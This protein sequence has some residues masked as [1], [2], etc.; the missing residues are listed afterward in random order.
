MQPRPEQQLVAD[1]TIAAHR[2][3]L[4]TITEAGTG[5]GKTV[6]S[7]LQAKAVSDEHPDKTVLILVPTRDKVFATHLTAKA[8]GIETHPYPSQKRI[9]CIKQYPG[10]TDL[11]HA[12]LDSPLCVAPDG[13]GG[14]G[15]MPTGGSSKR[16]ADGCCVKRP[17]SSGIVIMTAAMHNVL[18][19]HT[20]LL[21][22]SVVALIVDEAHSWFRNSFDSEGPE[23]TVPKQFV[24]AATANDV[25]LGTAPDTQLLNAYIRGLKRKKT[26]S[27]EQSDEGVT[28][29]QMREFYTH[30]SAHWFASYVA[31]L[32]GWRVHTVRYA[33]PL[34]FT[35]DTDVT[36]HLLTATAHDTMRSHFDAINTSSL[37]G[38]PKANRTTVRVNPGTAPSTFHL[39]VRTLETILNGPG[40]GVLVLFT[41]RRAMEQFAEA[42]GKVYPNLIVQGETLTMAEL[43]QIMKEDNGQSRYV[44]CGLDGLSEGL[45]LPG[46]ALTD[47]VLASTARITPTSAIGMWLHHLYRSGGTER[48]IGR[49][50]SEDSLWW[51]SKVADDLYDTRLRQ[52]AG[53]LLR[54]PEDTGRVWVL[55]DP[56][57]QRIDQ[58]LLRWLHIHESAVQ[59]HPT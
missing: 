58:A 48:M 40:G 55:M 53:R 54:G 17:Y 11:E 6:V 29:E 46:Q 30:P 7:V 19:T 25:Y 47:V 31:A 10:A 27:T 51:R 4:N 20:P 45:D 13:E 24:Q 57:K 5:S 26:M 49:P 8:L 42:F 41:A 52:S 33:S 50:L 23:V 22:D 35:R 9:L 44:A 38:I 21:G 3:G 59:W 12:C 16:C 14:H 37:T 28:E 1:E 18:F 56:T 34:R 2:Q 32:E 43:T 15:I 36:V 39:L